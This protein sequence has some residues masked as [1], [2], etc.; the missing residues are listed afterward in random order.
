LSIIAKMNFGMRSFERIN[1]LLRPNKSVERKMLSEMLAGISYIGDLSSYYYIGLGAVYFADFALFHKQLG[2]SHMVSIEID[3]NAIKRCEFNKPFACIELRTGSSSTVL[4]NLQID[5]NN[6]IIWLD[7][8]NMISDDVFSDIKTVLAKMTPNSFFALTINAERSCLEF[9]KEDGEDDPVQ[10]LER[11][12]GRDRF[13][14]EYVGKRLTEK[15]YLALL[16]ECLMNQIES[17]IITRN[18]V[19]NRPVVFQQTIFFEYKDGARMM[20]LGGFLF[21]EDE[22]RASLEKMAIQRLPF[23]KSGSDP[24]SIK[25]PILSPKEIQAL[26]SLLPCDPMEDNRFKNSAL[27]KFPVDNNMI[28]QYLSLYRYYPSYFEVLL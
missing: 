11:V 12:I 7:Y 16:Y 19:S 1:Y 28:N 9:I 18:R 24:F 25:C 10:A 14:K 6:S 27:N 22:V 15:S 20:T 5:T 3:E 8:D 23:Y 26:N 17:S 2:I 21:Y 4:P 13:P